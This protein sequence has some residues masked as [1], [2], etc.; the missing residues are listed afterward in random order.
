LIVP[1]SALLPPGLAA[2]GV[3]TASI[4]GVVAGADSAGISEAIVTVTNTANGARWQT[5]SRGRGRYSFEYLSV[6]GPYTVQVKAIGFKPAS[7]TGINL[8]LGDR[9]Q[10]RF[11]PRRRYG[12]AAL[13]WS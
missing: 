3:T 1:L 2:Q 6:G 10:V 12:G 7:R 9:R 11:L 5:V 4:F 13:S 8:S